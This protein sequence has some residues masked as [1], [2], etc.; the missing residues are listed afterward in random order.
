MRVNQMFVVYLL[1]FFMLFCMYNLFFVPWNVSDS[2]FYLLTWNFVFTF[3]VATSMCAAAN[4]AKN[5]YERP[6]IY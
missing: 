5:E 6:H 2:F 4:I 1:F 3:G